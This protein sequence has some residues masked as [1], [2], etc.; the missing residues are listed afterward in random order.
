M[1]LPLAGNALARSSKAL[2]GDAAA[3]C[4]RLFDTAAHVEAFAAWCRDFDPPRP[5][6]SLL[7]DGVASDVHGLPWVLRAAGSAVQ[8]GLWPA[9]ARVV[10]RSPFDPA[11][12][13]ADPRAA[14]LD[15]FVALNHCWEALLGAM[16]RQQSAPCPAVGGAAAALA[17][18][19]WAVRMAT[20]GWQE[21]TD[22]PEWDAAYDRLDA[23]LGAEGGAA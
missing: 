10:A 12:A 4:G 15:V 11:A 2:E 18:A 7:P 17:G 5:H 22:S 6:R 8:A 3:L 20:Q 23:R 9:A 1:T 13:E 14:W 16:S 21:P 19:A